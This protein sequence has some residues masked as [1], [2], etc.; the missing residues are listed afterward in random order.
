MNTFEAIKTRKSV[1]SYQNRPVDVETIKAVV[2]A[3][4]MAAK[5]GKVYF[6]VITD[7]KLLDT[8]SE[9]GKAIMQKSG[10]DFLMK[11]ASMPGYSPIYHAPVMVVISTETTPD[12]QTQSM[13]IANAACAAE[14]ILLAATEMEL[15][16]CY[17]ASAILAFTDPA[18]KAAAEIAEDH[19]PV[20]AVVFGYTDDKAPHAPRPK[21]PDNVNYVG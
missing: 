10:N 11:A 12:P 17:L 5:A 14:N 9:T 20:C 6:S 1:R 2:H 21:N 15:G 3:G 7:A 8:I 13:G 18:L 16:S 19:Q 4:N